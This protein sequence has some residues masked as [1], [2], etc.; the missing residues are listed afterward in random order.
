MKFVLVRWNRSPSCNSS[1]SSICSNRCCTS[2]VSEQF[3]MR[4]K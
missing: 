3:S 1:W 2:A 4:K